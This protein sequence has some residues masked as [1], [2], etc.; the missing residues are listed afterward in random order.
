MFASIAE[1]TTRIRNLLMGTD[2][3]Y[4]IKV[5]RAMGVKIEILPN[6][7]I[8]VHGVG[9]NGL[10]RPGRP[11][12][13]G[14]SGTTMRILPG[15]LAGQDF[16]VILK[17]D[18]SLS[19]RPMNRIL[20]PLKRMGVIIVGRKGKDTYPPLKVKGTISLKTI[21]YISNIASA[22]VKTCVLLA[23]LF[24]HGI[25]TIKEPFKSRDHTERMLMQFGT[26]KRL[27]IRS[28]CIQVSGPVRLES[29]GKINIPGDMSSASFFIVAACILPDVKVTMKN[30]GLNPTRTGILDILNRMGAK[31]D[32]VY[33][34]QKKDN[35]CEPSG[36]VTARHSNL[37]GVRI[38]KKDVVRAIDEIPIIMVAACFAKGNT[39]IDGIGEL[40]VKE[41]DRVRSM[42]TNL[43][44]IGADIKIDASKGRERIVVSGDRVLHGGVVSSF[45]DHRTAMSMLIADLAIKENIKVTG[46]RCIDKSF[47]GFQRLISCLKK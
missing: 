45:G 29:P 26:G 4:T 40:R 20:T 15:I 30:I 46:L 25:T 31:I 17:G 43:R 35:F 23:G 39:I 13:L 18:R 21:D 19:S 3:L 47:P 34:K 5:F 7:T 27:R 33:K 36:S 9:L 38:S 12:Y 8:L 44:K 37:K 28:L 2:C 16:S 10:R 24:A 42:V 41:T 11:L 6:S 14:N 32:L 1:G 22:Q